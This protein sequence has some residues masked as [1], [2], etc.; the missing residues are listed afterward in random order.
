MNNISTGSLSPTSKTVTVI[1]AGGS[2]T[3]FWPLS[4]MKMP[5]QFLPLSN[6]G[7]S[8][9]LDTANR[10]G[11]LVEESSTLVVTNQ[12]L[13]DLVAK[14][15][16]DAAILSEPEQRN[17]APALGL[18][19][20]KILN[21][22]G[23]IPMV[24]LPSDHLIQ[25]IGEFHKA[26][27]RALEIANSSET[28]VTI[29]I[30]PTSPETGYGYIKRGNP[31]ADHYAVD[32][33]VEKPN[34][35]TAQKYLDSK[36]YYWN[37]GMFIWRP[38][39]FLRQVENHLPELYEKLMQIKDALTNENQ[40]LAHSLFLEAESVSVDVGVMERATNVSVIPGANLGWSDV[41]SWSSW[42]DAV[43]EQNELN[44]IKGDTLLVD[45]NDC[46]AVSQK[47]LIAAVGLENIVIVETDDAIMVCHKNES[48]RVR[49]L[50]D[51]LRENSRE[52]LL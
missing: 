24:C 21:D 43:E 42:S 9:I 1:M 29:G 27:F 30:E 49:E 35:E 15:L 41:G 47:R 46:V 7:D 32:K 34:R 36:D 51:K 38:T 8:L 52:E 50:V 14:H 20:I 37:S 11:K 26:L 48:Q 39:V 12:K 5:K 33:F 17:T 25:N 22:T 2:G 10:V 23:D 4:R 40:N 44:N 3:R 28:L 6:T 45:C 16:P 18:A 19:A 31:Q 13:T